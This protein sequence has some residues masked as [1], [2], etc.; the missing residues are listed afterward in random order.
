MSDLSRCGSISSSV[1]SMPSCQDPQ[2]VNDL[3]HPLSPDL[4]DPSIEVSIMSLTLESSAT[5]LYPRRK[6]ASIRSAQPSLNASGHRKT[7]SSTSVPMRRSSSSSAAK[8]P[9]DRNLI[10]D[11]WITS[12]AHPH[13]AAHSLIPTELVNDDKAVQDMLAQ[14]MDDAL[15][16]LPAKEE[17]QEKGRPPSP[18]ATIDIPIKNVEVTTRPRSSSSLSLRKWAGMIVGRGETRRPASSSTSVPPRPCIAQQQSFSAPDSPSTEEPTVKGPCDV[19]PSEGMM[20][21]FSF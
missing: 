13:L 20:L 4:D 1:L 18:A 19:N 6:T 12:T 8:A 11:E 7:Q 3:A 21:T 2:P 16:S 10:F 17:E 9:N 5:G 14:A 15:D